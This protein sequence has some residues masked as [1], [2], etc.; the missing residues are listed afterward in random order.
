MFFRIFFTNFTKT[1]FENCFVVK[2]KNQYPFTTKKSHTKGGDNMTPA[3]SMQQQ[4]VLQRFDSFL[5]VVFRNEK[6]NFYVSEKRRSKREIFFCE[7]DDWQVEAYADKYAENEFRF[8]FDR[9]EIM[10]T[11][12][13]I[14][15]GRLYEA[16]MQLNGLQR[17]IILMTF[18]L[19]MNDREI[20]E[21]LGCKTRKINYIKNSAYKNLAE[22]LEGPKK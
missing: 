13:T 11:T 8:L 1:P 14:H 20:S 7:L 4:E 16:L 6:I 5:K 15:D 10:N 21:V 9:F 12:V 19:G 17:D 2:G 18:W 3:P 22:I